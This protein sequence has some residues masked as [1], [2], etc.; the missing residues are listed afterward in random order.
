M[1]HSSSS[2][3]AVQDQNPS[4]IQDDPKTYQA[5][6]SQPEP[7]SPIDRRQSE[8]FNPG[9]MRFVRVLA[10]PALQACEATIRDF[11]MKGLGIITD[12]PLEPGT[13]I[14]FQLRSAQSGLSGMLSGQ[15]C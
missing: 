8:R 11:S 1:A 6:D 2:A 3:E 9:R 10:R 7:R 5:H 14:A 4:A 15:V 13:I 12:R